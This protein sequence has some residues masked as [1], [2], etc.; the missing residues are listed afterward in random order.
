MKTLANIMT[1]TVNNNISV[2]F[3]VHNCIIQYSI[4]L[5]IKSSNLI[6]VKGRPQ[7][8]HAILCDYICEK[9]AAGVIAPLDNSIVP[10]N[11]VPF[12]S[13]KG[14]ITSKHYILLV[15]NKRELKR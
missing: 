13:F 2:N 11:Q 12:L 15:R 5:A 9:M 10:P 7:G 6:G 3:I 1:V 4:I 14:R 8:N